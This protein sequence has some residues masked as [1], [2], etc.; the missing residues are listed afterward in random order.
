[1][2]ALDEYFNQVFL[3]EAGQMGAGGGGAD[4]GDNGEFGTGTGMAVHERVEDT[5]AGGLADRGGQAGDGDVD[6]HG[7]MVDEVWMWNKRHTA[8]YDSARGDWSGGD[9]WRRVREGSCHENYLF[10]PI[11]DR[12]VSEGWVQ[13]VR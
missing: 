13:K 9:A 12:S 4:A 2:L 11:R 8:R 10:Y 7:S 5:G 1:M 3:G 6:I